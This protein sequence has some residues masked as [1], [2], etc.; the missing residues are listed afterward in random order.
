MRSATF[1][2]IIGPS[3]VMWL[4]V[5]CSNREASREKAQPQAAPSSGAKT[6][7]I[8]ATPNPVPA[9]NGFGT[10]TIAWDAGRDWAQVFISHDGEVET[11]MFGQGARAAGDAPWIQT[12]HTYEFRLYAGKDHKQLLDKVLVSRA[13]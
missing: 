7:W 5:G 13:K 6:P 10:T 4:L 12:G 2:T 3:L 1:K 8:T 9:G 11:R